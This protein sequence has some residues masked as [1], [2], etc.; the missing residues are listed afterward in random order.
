MSV[1][2]AKNTMHPELT[3]WCNLLDQSPQF[4]LL[5][6]AD[7]KAK[8]ASPKI[9]TADQGEVWLAGETRLKSGIALPSVFRTNTDTGGTLIGT[10]WKIKDTWTDASTNGAFARLGVPRDDA[11]PWT[12]RYAI[13]V[14]DDI[15]RS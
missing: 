2:A 3:K 9:V 11:T 7:G 4:I 8:L 5:V 12:W 14:E 1:Q 13:E 15:Y 10:Y 6:T